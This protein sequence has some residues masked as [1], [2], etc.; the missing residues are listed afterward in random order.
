MDVRED[1]RQGKEPFDRIMAAVNALGPDQALVLRA[2]FQPVPLLRVLEAQGFSHWTESRAPDDWSVWFWRADT[3]KGP[4]TATA[5]HDAAR[6]VD[7]RGLEPPQPLIRI[8]DLLD[9][10]APGQHLI[11]IHERRPP[12]LYPHIEERGFKHETTEPRPGEVRITIWREG[13]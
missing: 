4:R 2:P 12:L 3:A 7:V 5:P 1:I 11:V 9:T 10:L 8:L 6:V 13:S